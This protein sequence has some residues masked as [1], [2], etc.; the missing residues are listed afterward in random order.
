MIIR[1][2]NFT[3]KDGRSAVLHSPREEDINGT[4]EYLR[5]T[6]EE[7]EFLLRCPEECGKYTYESEKESF[8]RMNAAPNEIMMICEVEGRIAGNCDIGFQNN[9][10]TRHRANVAVALLKEFWGLGIGTKMFQEM[11]RLAKEGE[12]VLQIEL[13]FIEGNTRARALYEKMGF[14]ICGV[15]PDAIRL[16]NGTLLN[17]YIM[18]KK[19]DR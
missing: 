7:T 11:I 9:I 2:I 16:K 19:L 4:L 17:E 15:R 14:R 5:R 12:N 10:K 18:I 13:E 8:E 6:A 1:D 3:L